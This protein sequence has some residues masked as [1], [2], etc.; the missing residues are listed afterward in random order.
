MSNA[1]ELPS[2]ARA[3]AVLLLVT[4]G[5]GLLSLPCG[6]LAILDSS[7]SNSVARVIQN[8]PLLFVWQIAAL[9]LGALL[10]V[11]QIVGAAALLKRLPWSRGLLLGESIA[12]IVSTVFGLLIHLL[13][14]TPRVMNLAEHADVTTQ[15]GAI[16]AV[17]GG[18]MAGLFSLVIP[19]LTLI[20][21]TRPETR[22]ALEPERNTNTYNYPPSL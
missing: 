21:M 3:V 15:A 7:P 22:E 20:A 14:L 9:A 17:A 19:I 10:Y 8:D 18:S 2:L 11:L 16:G 13:V 5:L 1:K 4:G 12:N 6:G